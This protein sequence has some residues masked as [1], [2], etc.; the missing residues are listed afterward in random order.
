M[1]GFPVF[2][3]SIIG[4]L[5]AS[6]RGPRGPSTVNAIA[7]PAFIYRIISTSPRTPPRLDEP[8]TVPKPKPVKNLAMYSPSK[9]FDVRTTIPWPRIVNVPQKIRSC[10]SA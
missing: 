2:L 6:Y 9:L 4:P 1:I 7:N 10:Q 8:R 5:L 3:A